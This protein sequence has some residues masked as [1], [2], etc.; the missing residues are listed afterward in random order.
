M[1]FLTSYATCVLY[2][3]FDAFTNYQAQ[4]FVKVVVSNDN[5]QYHMCAISWWIQLTQMETK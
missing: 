5:W 2:W 4:V 3:I 1:I